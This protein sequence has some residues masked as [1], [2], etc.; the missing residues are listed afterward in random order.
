MTTSLS[1]QHVALDPQ[2]SGAVLCTVTK[3]YNPPRVHWTGRLEEYQRLFDIQVDAPQKRP[4]A[5]QLMANYDQA[6]AWAREL[7]EMPVPAPG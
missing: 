2:D 6:S 4:N 1:D 7:L 5:A 3:S